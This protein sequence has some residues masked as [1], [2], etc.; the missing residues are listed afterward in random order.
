MMAL[1]IN[2]KAMKGTPAATARDPSAREV[3][4]RALQ[5][6]L[7]LLYCTLQ[8]FVICLKACCKTSSLLEQS[9]SICY[10][11]MSLP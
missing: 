1:S 9:L 11:F 8:V 2:P 5:V 4:G 7:G 3:G 6:L 10:I